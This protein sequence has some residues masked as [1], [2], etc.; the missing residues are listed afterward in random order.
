M[1]RNVVVPIL[2]ALLLAG[3][4][5]AGCAQTQPTRFY[6]LSGL[7]QAPEQPARA[8]PAELRIGVG[9]VNLPE[10]LNRPQLVTRD[11]R[12]R[13]LLADFDS[14]VEPLDSMFTR[15]LAEN[16]SLLLGTDDVL[17]LPQRR[18][19]P[20]DFQVEVDVT[21]F[22][23]DANGNAVLDARWWLFGPRGEDLLQ[24]TRST[25]VESAAG[26]DHAAGAAALSRALGVMSQEIARAITDRQAR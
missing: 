17:I 6:T 16:L 18:P 26:G 3:L 25:I 4:G 2:A 9:P 7:L 22:D 21:R 19:F 8:N 15:V 12:N 5:L 10:Y 23:V 24:S 11:G 1:R 14:W 20:F 13:V